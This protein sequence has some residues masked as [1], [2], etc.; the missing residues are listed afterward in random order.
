MATYDAYDPGEGS[1][2]DQSG[3]QPENDAASNK[4]LSSDQKKAIGAAAVGTAALGG[5]A[6][7]LS[8]LEDSEN[9][10]SQDNDTS[11]DDDDANRAGTTGAVVATTQPPGG[12]TPTPV[13]SDPFAGLTGFDKAFAE[14]RHAMGP[15]HTF[16][17]EGGLYNTYTKEEEAMLTPDERNAFLADNNL[18]PHKHAQHETSLLASNNPDELPQVSLADEPNV[19]VVEHDEQSVTVVSADDVNSSGMVALVDD[20]NPDV[21][22]D[23]L[24]SDLETGLDNP[25]DLS[26]DLDDHSGIGAFT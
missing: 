20:A 5:A 2:Y 17:Y 10:V 1:A 22:H 8:M 19:S 9:Q 18:L 15:G 13:N 6:Y 4:S 12:A 25:T 16:T 26:T 3:Q 24:I 21:N 14:A 11:G 7:G 23:Q